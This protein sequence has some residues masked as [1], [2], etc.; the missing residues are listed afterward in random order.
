MKRSAFTLIELIFVIVIIGVLSAVAIPKFVNL[1]SNAEVK[2]TIKT[3]FDAAQ[4]A[5]EA[6]VNLTDLED[7]KSFELSDIV[8]LKGKNWTYKSDDTNGSYTFNQGNGAISYIKLDTANRDVNLTINC[9]KFTDATSQT[10]CE[11]DLNT[12]GT[13]S[14]LL[15]Y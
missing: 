7:N 6:A 15:N 13:Y 3:S 11:N 12:T 2:G 1:K 5:S 8:S 4:A 14:T 9:T 10:K